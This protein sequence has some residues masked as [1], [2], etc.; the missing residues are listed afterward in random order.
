MKIRGYGKKQSRRRKAKKK[1]EGEEKPR[2]NEGERKKAAVKL[3]KAGAI[4]EIQAK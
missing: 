3:S 4:L 2:V 1:T